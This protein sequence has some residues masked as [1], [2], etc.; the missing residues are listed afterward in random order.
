MFTA[1]SR[2]TVIGVAD[3]VDFEAQE[4]QVTKLSKTPAAWFT[5]L[6]TLADK[7]P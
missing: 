3:P 5:R 2:R 4:P 6:A 1:R 7:E